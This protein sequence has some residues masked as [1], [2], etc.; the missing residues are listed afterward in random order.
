MIANFKDIVPYLNDEEKCRDLFERLRW[1]DGTECPRCGHKEHIYKLRGKSTRPGVYKCGSCRRPFTV[2]VN[3]VFEGTRIPLSSWLYAIYL[4]CSSKKGVSAKQLERE[5]GI[6]YKSAWFMCHRVRLAMT[7]PPLIG[8][9]G[10]T[11]EV[12]ETY[13]GGKTHK[14]HNW[15]KKKATVLTLIERGGKVRT[16]PMPNT[17]KGYLQS[18]IR[19]NVEET[20]HIMTDSYRSYRGLDK[21]FASHESVDHSKEY[22]RG[23]I[24]TNFAESYHSLLKRSIFG[25]HHHIS[26]K[27]LPR[28]LREREFCWN[29]RH[30]TDGTRTM[31]AIAGAKGKRLMYRE[32][33]RKRKSGHARDSQT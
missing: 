25:T 13:I 26:K 2:T 22:V 16:F 11:V 33:L 4:M 17:K 14:L 5:L 12:D 32:P 21:H 29:L 6:T 23:I 9:L 3:S 8:K 1:P 15:R 20:A 30:A 24:H 27:H 28:Y 10:G 7:Q 19:L 18:L 31:A